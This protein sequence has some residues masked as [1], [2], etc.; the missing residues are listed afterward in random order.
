MKKTI[1]MFCSLVLLLSAHSFSQEIDIASLKQMLKD[2]DASREYEGDLNKARKD[3]SDIVDQLS[4]MVRVRRAA[5]NQVEQGITMPK[6]QG[7]M[8]EEMLSAELTVLPQILYTNA[9]ITFYDIARGYDLF[10]PPELVIPDKTAKKYKESW[11]I[12]NT[13]ADAGVPTDAQA[14]V[15]SFSTDI[16]D[17]KTYYNIINSPAA[18]KEYMA[19]RWSDV[20]LKIDE[21]SGKTDTASLSNLGNAYLLDEFYKQLNLAINSYRDAQAMATQIINPS[22]Y[23]QL[24]DFRSK[25]A[26]IKISEKLP[27]T[28][29]MNMDNLHLLRD[30]AAAYIECAAIA[31]PPEV[32]E[33]ADTESVSFTLVSDKYKD[34]IS[35]E[36]IDGLNRFRQMVSPVYYFNLLNV[37]SRTLSC[38]K[39]ALAVEPGNAFLHNRVGNLYRIMGLKKIT[40]QLEKANY[41]HLGYEWNNQPDWKYKPR[42]ENAAID[43]SEAKELFGQA[44]KEYLI[45]EKLNDDLGKRALGI[46]HLSFISLDPSAAEL[47]ISFLQEAGTED[48]SL[49]A[50]EYGYYL[51][52]VTRNDM[53]YL[54]F[55]ASLENAF[56][57]AQETYLRIPA[58]SDLKPVG[59]SLLGQDILLRVAARSR[60]RVL[61]KDTYTKLAAELEQAKQLD[62]DNPHTELLQGYMYFRRGTNMSEMKKVDDNNYTGDRFEAYADEKGRQLEEEFEKEFGFNNEMVVKKYEPEDLQ[63]A[64]KIYN[65]VAAKTPELAATYY[66]LGR[67]YSVLG[68]YYSVQKD[69]VRAKEYKD[70]AI[71]NLKKFLLMSR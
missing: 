7:E 9:T 61:D 34:Q 2:A 12:I 53:T 68:L 60:K 45:V 39:Q 31:L 33:D 48:T 59:A 11:G 42:D 17:R 47:A 27:T 18:Q 69:E 28:S 65:D 15:P 54:Q 41:Y 5:F 50:L 43:L 55:P 56:S 21:L 66:Y 4:K 46:Y 38:F 36:R 13:S 8:L 52:D 67:A 63:Q 30:Q 32:A 64:V 16:F 23:T 71:E 62:P 26:R 44:L 22:L 51:T 37:D 20:K 40:E 19:A 1:I 10:L 57:M 24:M 3:Y 35:R 49:F 14:L 25:M 58:A 6:W 29:E 70:L